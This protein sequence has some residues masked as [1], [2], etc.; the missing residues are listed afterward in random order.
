MM[1]LKTIDIVLIIIGMNNYVIAILRKCQ[2]LLV[3]TLRAHLVDSFLVNETSSFAMTCPST[4][5]A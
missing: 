3:I 2:K 1:A 5:D 4:L